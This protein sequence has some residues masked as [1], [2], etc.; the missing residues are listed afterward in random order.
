MSRTLKEDAQRTYLADVLPADATGLELL[1]RGSEHGW[2]RKD[3]HE[4][5]NGKGRTL[6]I[7]ESS[8]AYLAAGYTSLPWT[9]DYGSKE[10]SSA[11][12][13]ALT[14]KMQ[15]FKP[16][17]PK[18]AVAHGSNWGPSWRGSLNAYNNPMNR[19][20]GG[21]CFTNEAC[22]GLYRIP[23]DSEGNS[24]LTG[25]GSGYKTDEKKFTIRELEVFLVKK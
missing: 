18:G 19:D 6:S 4:R 13:C 1:Y 10:D 14:N 17:N 15:L 21:N 16:G 2:D 5:C 25:E 7:F 22:N 24:I 3:F 23:T 20:K 8:K 9:S 11:F 12:L